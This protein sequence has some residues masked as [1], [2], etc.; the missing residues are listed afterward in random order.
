MSEGSIQ[1]V[2]YGFPRSPL[3]G[4]SVNTV[5][6]QSYAE[7]TGAPRFTVIA[8]SPKLAQYELSG[9]GMARRNILIGWGMV[10]VVGVLL[11]VALLVG[12]V[13]GGRGDSTQSA[14]SPAS[15][16]GSTTPEGGLRGTAEMRDR[17]FVVNEV[18]WDYVPPRNA[19]RPQ[20][21]NALARANV[22]VTN[23]CSGDINLN[24]VTFKMQDSNGVQRDSLS[25]P[26]MPNAITVGGI[27][28]GGTPSGNV[29]LEYPQ[30]DPGLKLVYIPSGARPE[31]S[32]TV[33]LQG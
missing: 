13:I 32:A 1:D 30:G 4:S 22:T 21:G 2:G 27:A 19:P 6:S 17:N 20:V 29:V 10:V 18:E 12:V 7:R 28:P 26:E 9:V 33:N 23:T 14:E 16:P 24:P 25:A 8:L 3:L 11:F 15:E 31:D 5:S